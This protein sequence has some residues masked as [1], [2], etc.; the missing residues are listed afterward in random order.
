MAG[1]APASAAAEGPNSGEL[2]RVARGTKSEKKIWDEEESEADLVEVLLTYF[3]HQG[4]RTT[5]WKF[6]GYFSLYPWL[7]LAMA[8]QV[9]SWVAPGGGERWI[10]AVERGWLEEECCRLAFSL[11]L[12]LSLSSL[13]PLLL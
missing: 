4:G 2:L 12:L 10:K 3:A 11:R 7:S 13:P 5:L 6:C 8:L 9:D 1:V